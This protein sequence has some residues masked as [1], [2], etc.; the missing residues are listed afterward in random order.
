MDN[1]DVSAMLELDTSSDDVIAVLLGKDAVDV[2]AR[3]DF[4]VRPVKSWDDISLNRGDEQHSD[5]NSTLR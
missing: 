1:M 5:Q 2:R 4:Q 3:E